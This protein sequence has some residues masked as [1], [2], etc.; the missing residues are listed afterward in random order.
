[1]RSSCR[2]GVS[3]CTIRRSV[4]MWL[5]GCLILAAPSLRAQEFNPT[6][7]VGAG[8]Q[9]SF[10]NSDPK[11]GKN[12]T[13]Q[14]LLNHARIYLSGDV[15]KDIS[16]MFNTD[17]NSGT[18][19]MGIMDAVGQFHV[20]P[21]F[22]IWF[23]RF[24]PPSDRA[25]LYGP[26]YANEWRV[27]TDGVQDG[28]P[29]IFQGR[30]NGV[31]YWGDYK[32]GTATVKVSV[33]AFDGLS[34][35]G[36]KDVLGAARVQIDF[37][38]PENGYYQNGTYYGDKNL[39]AI[40]GATQVQGS[41]TATTLDFLMERK[42][43]NGGAFSIESEYSRY[44]RLGGYDSHYAKSQGAYGLA[45]FL[46][47]KQVGIGKFEVLGKWAYAEFTNGILPSNPYYRQKTTAI[48]VDYVIKQFDARVMTFY[49]DVRFSAVNINTWEAGVGLQFQISKQIK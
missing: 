36:N 29:G 5:A 42:V 39:L 16:V 30:D 9:T 27:F 32:A 13:A 40:G 15:T 18:N 11:G 31:A 34:A 24:L 43:M 14:L 44:N 21:K 33:G 10:Q 26:F 3:V 35:T 23:G 41:K 28:Y 38:D 7:S 19:T 4:F 17:Y 48:N 12:D 22:N 37:W 2:T 8:V 45:S 6:L 46:F 1:M 25:N 47:P 20:S 49:R